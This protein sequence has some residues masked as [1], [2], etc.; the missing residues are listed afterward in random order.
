MSIWA[1]DFETTALHPYKGGK[2]FSY[3]LCDENGNAEVHRVDYQSHTKNQQGWDR[4]NEIMVD[5]DIELVAHN[6][7]FELM[8]CLHTPEIH[9][10]VWKVWHDTMIMSQL[11]RNL[12]PSHALD[13]LAWEFGGYSRE[14]DKA[15]KKQANEFGGYHKVRKSLM[16]KYQFAD[17]ERGMLLW[18]F[19]LPKIKK[20]GKKL[21]ADYK[22]EMNLISSTQRMEDFGLLVDEQEALKLLNWLQVEFDNVQIE[23]HKYL[24]EFVNLNSSVQLTSLL[25]KAKHY[26]ILKLTKNKQ[27]CTDKDVLL[28]LRDKYP[29]DPIFNMIFRWRSY[30]TGITTINKYLQ[31]RDKNG[32]VH[33]NIKTNHA[34][35]GRESSANPNMQNVAKDAALKNPFT[36]PARRC[37]CVR[38]RH[39]LYLVD[40]SGIEMRLI[41]DRSGEEELI[42]I[43][44]QGGDPHALAAATFYGKRFI[45]LK[46][47][48]SEFGLLRSAAKNGQFALAYGAGL[49]K[50][51]DTLMLPVL[52]ARPGFENYSRRFP[53]VAG[54]TNT[55]AAK[56]KEDGFVETP[57]GRKLWVPQD[58]AYIGTNYLIQGTAAGI[59]KRAQ[60]RVDKYLKE[61]WND[62]I[63]MVLPIHDELLISYPR[64]LLKYRDVVLATVAHIM[65]TISEIEVPLE[66]EWKVTNSTWDKAW[67]IGQAPAIDLGES[68]AVW[69]EDEDF[70]PIEERIK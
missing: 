58:K 6:A 7:K 10:P 67:K 69:E 27:P 25:Y 11:L 15:V 13:Y 2:V 45:S 60:V 22:N 51:A 63:R 54:F 17:A 20:G 36:V 38:P 32:V 48:D 68:W 28:K 40:Y 21:W 26:P 34:R 61:T 56:V 5:P 9:L 31:L 66:V 19:F 39:L 50:I 33:P 57:F 35:T 55:T 52:E 46:K 12:A 29:K 70:K 37:F 62:E 64:S 8:W 49:G 1:L 41:I 3:S 65:T 24:G 59:L 43:L 16:D 44:K 30:S 18:M 42:E 53:K 4:L 14:L 23:C 47:S